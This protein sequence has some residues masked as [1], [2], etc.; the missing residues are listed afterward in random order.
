MGKVE[1]HSQ[2][3]HRLL[4]MYLKI[5]T[6]IVKSQRSHDFIV[7][8]L[9][10][11]DG[12]AYWPGGDEEW[13]G[14]AQ[15]TAKW[16]SKAGERAFCILNE[17]D[18]N[19]IDKLKENTKRYS[20]VIKEILSKDAN[21]IHQYILDKYISIDAHSIFILDP[22]NHTELK[23]STVE[24]IA[25]HSKEEQYRGENFIRRPELI[26]NL[27][28]FTILKSKTQNRQLITEFFGTDEWIQA[29]QKAEKENVSQPKALLDVYRKQLNK[30]YDETG[31]VPIEIRTLEFNAP[32]YYLIF[33]AT[34]PLAKKIHN[35][36]E[37]WVKKK[38]RKFRKE[39]YALKLIAEAKRKQIK[40]LDEWIG[41]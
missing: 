28:T 30:Y 11:N 32:I 3:K 33:V 23:F 8:D 4:G 35:T 5:C 24:S 26:I 27:P 25:R 41:K 40:P 12:I 18:E 2:M 15:I 16:V 37:D 38:T 39:G 22:F 29:V 6:D 20:D 14:S 13:E 19:L 36:F 17:K 9:Y 21:V 1:K 34:H 10:A 31:I 7:V